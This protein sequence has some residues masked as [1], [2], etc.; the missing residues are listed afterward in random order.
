MARDC[1][2]VARP[3][4][5]ESWEDGAGCGVACTPRRPEARH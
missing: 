5:S 4:A 1:R 3:P 2:R